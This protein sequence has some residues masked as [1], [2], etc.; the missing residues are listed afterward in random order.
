MEHQNGYWDTCNEAAI[1]R[2]RTSTWSSTCN[3]APGKASRMENGVV[4]RVRKVLSLEA[5]CGMRLQ[6]P[7]RR[8]CLTA[9]EQLAGVQKHSRL[10]RRDRGL[11]NRRRHGDVNNSS[12]ADAR[13][14]NGR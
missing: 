5:Q 14:T 3:A 8:V 2:W 7:P 11:E 12:R 9:I 10:G 6:P 1:K 13:A 4:R